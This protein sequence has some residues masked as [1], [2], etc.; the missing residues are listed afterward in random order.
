MFHHLHEQII[1]DFGTGFGVVYQGTNEVLH[2][3]VLFVVAYPLFVSLLWSLSAIYG[4]V[5]GRVLR[6]R[7]GG[8]GSMVPSYTVMVPFYGN[9][10]PLRKTLHSLSNLYPPPEEVLLIDD[11]SGGEIDY[12]ALFER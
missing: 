11:G 6:G 12:S 10:E 2:M 8:P 9:D 5:Q 7:S 4:E 1:R 3:A